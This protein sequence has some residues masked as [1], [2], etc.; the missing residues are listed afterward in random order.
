MYVEP[1]IPGSV[2]GHPL[3]V[4]L[5]RRMRPHGSRP[6]ARVAELGPIRLAVAEIRGA[7]AGDV[8][9]RVVLVP[10]GIARSRPKGA[11]RV[12]ESLDISRSISTT[13]GMRSRGSNTPESSPWDY[14][15]L[16]SIGKANFSANS[17]AVALSPNALKRSPEL[18]VA[19]T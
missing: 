16:M 18:Q 8:F 4:D 17:S 2:M 1:E 5:E 13:C 10:Q 9:E 7:Q 12:F 14:P 19:T 11:A 15:S 6:R 3:A